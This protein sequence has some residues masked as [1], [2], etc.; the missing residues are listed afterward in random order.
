MQGNKKTQLSITDSQ[1]RNEE[2]E[3]EH[4]SER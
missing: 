3:Y 2:K 1:I 4:S